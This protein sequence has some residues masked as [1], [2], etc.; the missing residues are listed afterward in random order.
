M[1]F[2][3]LDY[4]PHTCTKID[5]LTLDLEKDMN[6]LLNIYVEKFKMH[7]TMKLR[8]SF[9]DALS[10]AKSEIEDLQDTISDL[11]NDIEKLKQTIEELESERK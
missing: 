3:S 2:K 9:E 11:E 8:E 7:G 1:Y 6:N 4:C 5:E 10:D